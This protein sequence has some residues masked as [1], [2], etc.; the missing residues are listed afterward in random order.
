MLLSGEA[1]GLPTSMP[2]GVPLFGTI[3]HPTQIYF[4]L[5]ALISLGIL[6]WLARRSLPTGTLAIAY[7]GD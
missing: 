2:W 7:V 1:F 3:R 4:A 5:T 6:V